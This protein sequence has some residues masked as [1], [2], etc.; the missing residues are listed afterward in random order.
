MAGIY[1]AFGW[2]FVTFVPSLLR[3]VGPA[4][5]A[6]LLLGGL[7]YTAGAAVYALQRPDPF[8]RIFGYHEIFHLFVVAAAALHFAAV[9]LTLRA[10]A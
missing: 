10:L 3:T 4:V 9:S 6:L 8:P 5:F 2:I 1:V 7:V